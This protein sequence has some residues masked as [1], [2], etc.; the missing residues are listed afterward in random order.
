[1]STA[2]APSPFI[3]FRFWKYALFALVAAAHV[4]LILFFRFNVSSAAMEEAPEADV[5][6]LVDFTEYVPPPPPAPEEPIVEVAEQP[7]AAETVIAVEKEIVE[8]PSAPAAVE[9]PEYMPQ[10]LISEVPGIPT[11]EILRCIEYPLMAERQ[12]IEAVVYVEL[13]IDRTGLVRR[14]AVLRDPGHGFAEAAVA[15]L[16][17]LKCT[18]AKANGE[19]VAVRYRYPIRFTL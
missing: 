19:P 16:T 4:V 17:G 10:H 1:M 15:A 13:Y 5:I 2:A 3:S 12:G 8:R 6:K 14:I 18:P 7:A 11:D 9:A